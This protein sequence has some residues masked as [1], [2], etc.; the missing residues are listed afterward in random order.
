M[1]TNKMRV[2]QFA[3]TCFDAA[4][5]GCSR[6]C[7]IADCVPRVP[8][9]EVGCA[10]FGRIPPLFPTIHFPGATASGAGRTYVWRCVTAQRNV[11]PRPSLFLRFRQRNRRGR[12]CEQS[13]IES[14]N[15]SAS[16]D[17]TCRSNSPPYSGK[18]CREG[19][20][21]ASINALDSGA[22]FMVRIEPS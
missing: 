19:G 21:L 1:L 10:C 16:A 15:A 12:I 6:R 5:V 8:S 11:T 7:E 2:F 18:V 9:F 4:K 3:L 13:A 14:G 22:P 17:P 20:A